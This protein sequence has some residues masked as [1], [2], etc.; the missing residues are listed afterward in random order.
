MTDFNLV[1]S[2]VRHQTPLVRPVTQRPG[3]DLQTTTILVV[4]AV[5]NPFALRLIP[6][7]AQP[8]PHPP[9]VANPGGNAGARGQGSKRQE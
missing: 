7:H 6:V 9:G 2:G 4:S 8:P 1:R 5:R 3:P